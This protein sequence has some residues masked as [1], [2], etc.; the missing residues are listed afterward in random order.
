MLKLSIFLL[1][2]LFVLNGVQ[3]VARSLLL[4]NPEEQARLIQSGSSYYLAFDTLQ[5]HLMSYGVLIGLGVLAIVALK[6]AVWLAL[7]KAV[8]L[9]FDDMAV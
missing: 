5:T 8:W 4:A 2:T 7:K 3:A 6:T 1:C 9:E